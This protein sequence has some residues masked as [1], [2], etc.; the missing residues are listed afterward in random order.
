MKNAKDIVKYQVLGQVGNH[1]GN[2]LNKRQSPIT[3]T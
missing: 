2:S 3:E 1:V